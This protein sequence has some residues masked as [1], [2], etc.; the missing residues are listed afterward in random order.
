MDTI[1]FYVIQTVVFSETISFWH[2]VVPLNNFASISNC[3]LMQG[4]SNKPLSPLEV[5][6]EGKG[7]NS[8]SM[9]LPQFLVLLNMQ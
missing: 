9:I 5:C 1:Q 4:K 6:V 8:C 2:L 7:E 3:V